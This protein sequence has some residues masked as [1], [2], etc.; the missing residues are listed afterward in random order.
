M[1]ALIIKRGVIQIWLAHIFI[2]TKLLL[3]TDR[4]VYYQSP[5]NGRIKITKSIG[6]RVHG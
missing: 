3:T 4:L 5:Q 6:G 1:H 2:F